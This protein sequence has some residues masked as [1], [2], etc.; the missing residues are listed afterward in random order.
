MQLNIMPDMKE[1]KSFDIIIPTYKPGEKFLR[2]FDMLQRQHLPYNKLILINTEHELMSEEIR[3]KVLTDER[4]VLKD[5]SAD[6]FDHAATRAMAVRL[7]SSDAFICMTDDAVPADEFLTEK[8][9]AGLNQVASGN[10]RDDNSCWAANKRAAETCVNLNENA[11]GARQNQADIAANKGV[12]D[13]MRTE[14]NVQV[15]MCYARQLAAPDADESEKYV[16][17]FNYPEKSFV[18]TAADL[19]RLG[20]KTYFAS[21]VCCAY[22]REIFESLG[23]FIDNAIFNE[24][25]IYAA[26]AI[27]AGYGIRYEAEALV[28]HSHNYTAMQQLHRN[29]DLGLSQRQHPEVFEGLSSEGEG[30]KLVTATI[31]HL[32]SSGHAP[33]IPVF[34]WRTGFRYIGYR[35]GKRYDRL[36]KGLVRSLAMNKRYV[37]KHIA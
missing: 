7:S 11:D 20:I 24:D 2:L 22:N 30:F 5:I 32:L 9:I 33:D 25:M 21:D 29:F 26:A 16:R 37:D 31:R 23:G 35:A 19:T 3:A 8:L 4:T 36:P 6:E 1:I 10:L 13:P 14:E 27:K 18:K 34:I 17:V 15:A 28:V 12:G